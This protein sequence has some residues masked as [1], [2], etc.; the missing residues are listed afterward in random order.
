VADVTCTRRGEAAASVGP[1]EADVDCLVLLDRV[2]REDDRAITDLSADLIWQIA[3][4][5]ISPM[6]MS[7]TDF[8]AWKARERRPEAA[9]REDLVDEFPYLR[10][11]TVRWP[12]S[13]RSGSTMAFRTAACSSCRDRA[14]A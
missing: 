2:D 11:L 7:V 13:C 9:L 3:G 1:D 8:E 5:V 12:A 4:V 6:V 10:R 14:R